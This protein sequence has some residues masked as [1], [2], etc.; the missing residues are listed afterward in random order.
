MFNIFVSFK[1]KFI[2]F[3]NDVN[4]NNINYNNN[5]N[6]FNYVFFFENSFL[7][8]YKKNFLYFKELYLISKAD[9]ENL[10][11]KSN[12]EILKSNKY[13]LED[14]SENLLPVLDSLESTLNGKFLK[15]EDLL[16]GIRLTLKIFLDVFLK[17]NISFI[18]PKIG[19]IFDPYKHLAISTI[20]CS[21]KTDNSIVNILQKGYYIFERILRPAL[22]VVN[23]V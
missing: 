3:V 16:E 13:C 9:F 15:I 1:E 12:E 7:N 19:D 21:D 22:V 18:L 23:K 20:S 6:F 14:F 17:K 2:F 10:K 8:I 5:L 4:L 11:K